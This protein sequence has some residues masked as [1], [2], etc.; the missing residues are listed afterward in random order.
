MKFVV[1]QVVLNDAEAK[2]IAN[3]AVKE[4]VDELKD[5]VYD[6]EDLLDDITTE[7]LRNYAARWSTLI[8]NLSR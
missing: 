4:W 1:V 5:V 3:S 2:Q 7:A 6:A 8:L